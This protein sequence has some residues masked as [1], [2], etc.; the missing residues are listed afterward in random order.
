M[1]GMAHSQVVWA[2]SHEWYVRCE[3][4]TDG[5]YRVWCKSKRPEAG[6]VAFTDFHKLSRWAGY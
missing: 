1:Q 5:T 3:L 6:L 2:S 4:L